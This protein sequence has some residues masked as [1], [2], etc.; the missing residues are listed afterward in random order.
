MLRD[1]TFW[2]DR[3]GTAVEVRAGTASDLPELLSWFTEERDQT[4]E[5]FYCN[6]TIIERCFERGDGLCAVARGRILGFAVIQSVGESGAIH[7]VE[8]TPPSAAGALDRSC[9]RLRSRCCACEEPFTSTWSAPRQRARRFPEST[10]SRTTLL[11]ENSRRAF[12]HPTLRLYFSD[13]RPPV[14]CPWA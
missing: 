6:K 1:S 3:A 12:D 9:S 14:T 13:W 7:I 11:P 4:G 10:A 8:H 2:S 5:G